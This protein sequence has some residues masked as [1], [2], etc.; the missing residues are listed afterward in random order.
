MGRVCV[1]SFSVSQDGFGAGPNQDREHPLGVG[2]EALHEWIFATKTGRSM[3]GRDGGDEGVDDERFRRNLEAGGPTIMGRNM[4]GPIRGSWARS[5]WRGWWGEEPPFH[6]PVFVLTHYERPDLVVGDTT[7]IFVTGGVQDALSRAR[8]VAGESDVRVGGGVA[9]IRQLLESHL[10]DE[11]H[12]A[13]VP[14]QLGSGEH[15]VSIGSWPK[16][17]EVR[18]ETLGERVR[19]VDLIRSVSAGS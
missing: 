16:G 12:L 13:L 14:V 5:N 6:G 3:V 4:F 2:G 11:L 8:A 7:F 9:T 1:Y 10:I 18:G 15:L 17:Y 19:H